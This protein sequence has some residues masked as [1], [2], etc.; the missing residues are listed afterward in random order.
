ME[1]YFKIGAFHSA[2]S[3]SKRVLSVMCSR[4]CPEKCTFCSTPGMWGQNTRW[5]STEHIMREISNDV[6]KKIAL[7]KYNLMMTLSL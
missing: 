3:K 5:R 6:I 4:G 2:K 7:V 1:A